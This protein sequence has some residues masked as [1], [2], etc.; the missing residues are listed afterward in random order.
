M[1]QPELAEA[2]AHSDVIHTRRGERVTLRFVASA[3]ADGLQAYVRSLSPRS[4]Y[5]R[6]LGA[7][8]ELPK[9]VLDDF[10]DPGRDDRFT[11]IATM[12]V[13]GAE[14]IVGEARYAL[15]AENRSL[16]FGLSVHDRWQGHGIGPALL[17]NLQCRA[18]AL[19]AVSLF[20][21]TLRTNE[22]M[23]AVAK[24]AGFVLHQHPQDWTL[25][26]FEKQVALGA[27][28]TGCGSLRLVTS[29]APGAE[30]SLRGA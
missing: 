9:A 26:R 16:E 1:S 19:G 28:A 10:V 5:N 8:S 11:L 27:A 13:G 14:V 15:H 18:A 30:A 21:D 24:A 25:V 17:K 4:R 20:G 6:F 22:V 23:I 29:V 3:D 12:D 2:S 7:M